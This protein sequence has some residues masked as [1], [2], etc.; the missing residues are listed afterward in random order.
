MGSISVNKIGH[1]RNVTVGDLEQ[2]PTIF[3]GG[4]DHQ[5]IGLAMHEPLQES[6]SRPALSITARD[7]RIPRMRRLYTKMEL[8]QRRIEFASIGIPKSTLA[9]LEGKKKELEYINTE[10]RS[11]EL[12]IFELKK[13]AGNGELEQA[14]VYFLGSIKN[15]YTETEK[16]SEELRQSIEDRRDQ[17]AK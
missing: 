4:N 8:I 9:D 12:Q 3:G 2:L 7:S 13:M 14:E 15:R 10:L 1:E 16:F 11:C 6:P 17:L 5:K